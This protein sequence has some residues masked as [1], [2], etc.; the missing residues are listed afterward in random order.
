M[1][2]DSNQAEAT[3]VSV[4]MAAY[5]GAE[6]IREQI[7]SILSELGPGDELVVVDDASTDKTRDVVSGVGDSRIR[8]IP[9]SVN[10]GYVRTFEAALAHSRGEYVFLSDQDDVWIPGRVQR[11]VDAL[12]DAEVVASNFSF[13]GQQPRAIESIRLRSADSGRRWANLF[14]LWV[15][16]R[17]YYGCSMAMR[18]SVL[19]L[20]LPFPGF[21]TETHDQWIAMV[22][23]LAGTMHHVEEDTLRRRLHE[24]NT[25]PKQWRSLRRILAARLMLL[26]AFLVAVRRIRRGSPA[27]TDRPA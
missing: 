11:M 8:L 25:S 14:A 10:R 19:S 9:S 23:N 15:G 27:G 21:L 12:Q 7:D 26:R 4:C 17:P 22:A 5:N 2:P 6:H 13:F 16:Y 3:R 1:D 20:I 24:A 18:S